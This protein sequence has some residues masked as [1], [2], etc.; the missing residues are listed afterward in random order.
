MLHDEQRGIGDIHA[1]LNY[2]SAHQQVKVALAKA[3]HNGIFFVFWHSPVEQTHAEFPERT[4]L[5]FRGHLLGSL[6]I[7]S[8]GF[9]HERI[10]EIGLAALAQSLLEALVQLRPPVFRDPTGDDGLPAWW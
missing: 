2:D 7:E 5:E 8:L 6:E 4:L 10:D 1:Y 3:F 9:R